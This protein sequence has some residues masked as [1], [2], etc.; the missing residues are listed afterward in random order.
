MET[1]EE[2]MADIRTRLADALSKLDYDELMYGDK[3]SYQERAGVLLSLPG[4]TI[5]DRQLLEDAVDS[6]RSLGWC[7]TTHA[8]MD[9]LLAAAN[10]SGR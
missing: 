4:I 8:N 9:A 10:I 1:T 7:P 3:K 6:Y 2:T 5:V